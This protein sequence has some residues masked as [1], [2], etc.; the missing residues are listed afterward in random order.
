MSV[1]AVNAD[2][3]NLGNISVSSGKVAKKSIQPAH[4][5][6]TKKTKVIGEEEYLNTRTGEVQTFNVVEIQD[7]DAN[8]EKL[9]L[10]HILSAIDEIG[11]AKMKILNY[12]LQNRE[13]SNNSLI[14]T[15]AELS[16][17]TEISRAT[18]VTTLQTL[19]KHGIIKRRTGAVIL[20]PDVVFKGRHK[21]RMNVL[22]KYNHFT[23]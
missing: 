16:Q 6:N 8:F 22:Y 1:K 2:D 5:S 7:V 23:D 15:I 13:R 12:I 3:S 10:G 9:W 4:D 19:E 18:V 20:N 21:H 11:N 17:R 14:I